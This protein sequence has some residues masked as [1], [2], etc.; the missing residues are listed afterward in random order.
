MNSAI[1]K[2]LIIIQTKWKI[3]PELAEHVR[4]DMMDAD[5][6]HFF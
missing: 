5:G 4:K 2:E 6:I 3:W 1:D